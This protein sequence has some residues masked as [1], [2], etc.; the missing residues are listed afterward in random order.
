MR[1]LLPTIF[2]A[3]LLWL[4]SC[5]QQNKVTL[6]GSNCADE[7]PQRTNLTFSFNKDLINDSLMQAGGWQQE[8]FIKFTPNIDGFYRWESN[9]TLVFSPSSAL[10]PA[11]S[12][13]AEI[14]DAVCKFSKFKLG[15]IAVLNFHTAAQRLENF[16]AQWTI[17]NPS[18]KEIGIQADLYFTYPQSTTSLEKFISLSVNKKELPF[19]FSQTENS[20]KCALIVKGIQPTDKEYEIAVEIKKG[21]L[22]I[23]GKN[24]TKEPLKASYTLAS[25]FELTIGNI[26]AAHDG[27]EG[28]ITIF[29]SQKIVNSNMKSLLKISPSINFNVQSTDE[30][31]QITSSEFDASKV[32]EISIAK[33]LKGIIGGEMKDSYFNTVS[34][35]K[36]EP[37]IAFNDK[38]ATY[39]SAKGNKNLLVN[40]VN[41][42]KVKLIIRKVYEN[43]ILPALRYGAGGSYYDDEDYGN[44]GASYAASDIVYEEEINTNRLPKKGESRI[45]NFNF[46]DKLPEFKGIYHASLR[47]TDDYWINDSRIISLSD[48]GLIARQT[49]N[50]IIVF[51]NSI[52]TAKSLGGIE[53]KVF[54]NNNQLIGNAIT[55]N[56]G[57]ATIQLKKVNAPGFYPALV[58]AKSANDFNYISLRDSRIETSRFDV[59]G[60]SLSTTS[61]DAFVYG[62]RDMY[63]PGE[64]INLSAIVRTSEWKTAGEIPVKMK[65]SLPNGMEF[66]SLKKILNEQGSFEVSFDLPPNAITGSYLFELFTANDVLLASKSI[67]VEEFMPDR[68]K[69]ATQLEK[70]LIELNEPIV[71]KG[72][73]QNLFG[74]AAAERNYE[75]ELQLNYFNFA[76]KNFP[77]YN[78][79]L[80]NLDGYFQSTTKQGTTDATGSFKESFALPENIANKGI[81]KAS[82]FTT[83]FDETGRPVNR[84]NTASIFTQNIFLGIQH[85]DYYYQPLNENI[86]FG[87][88]AVNS[89]EQTTSSKAKVQII[90]HEFK[91]V[92]AKSWDY[93]RYESQVDD[94]ILTEQ[95]IDVSGQNTVFNFVPKTPGEYEIR[96]S[97]PEAQSYVQ[98]RFYSYGSWGGSSSN[99]E[100]N[101]EGNIDIEIDKESY[102]NGEQ[103]KLLFKT[104]FNGKMLVTVERDEVMEKFYLNVEN[105]TA[106]ATLQLNARHMPNAY[107]TATLFKAHTVSEMPLTV[108]H[109]FKNIAVAE[110]SRKINVQIEAPEKIRSNTHQKIAVK[111]APNSFITLAVVDEGILQITDYKSP[112]P[113]SFFYS[114]RALEVKGYDFYANLFPEIKTSVISVGGDGFD[115]SKRTNPITNKRV[116]LVRYWSGI[117]QTNSL[118][119]AVFEFDVPQF[120]GELRLMAVNYVNEKFGSAES[121]MK[122]ADP[123]VISAGLPRFLSPGDEADVSL[124]LSNTTR[125]PMNVKIS[126]ETAGALALK[127]IE[128][129]AL[130]I[131]PNSEARTEF[132]VMANNT[133][134]NA[135]VKVKAATNNESF[136][137]ETEIT[138]RPAASLQKIFGSGELQ[139][140]ENKIIT[141]GTNDF[142]KGT[143]SYTLIVS[144]SPLASFGKNLAELIQ[145]P[146]G[147]TE[148]ITAAAFPQIYF[149]ELSDAI[150]ANKQSTKAA[151]YNITEAIK[152]IKLRQLY[153]G[154]IAL[155]DNEGKENWWASVFAAHFLVEAKQNGYEVEDNF[156]N[157]LLLYLES[158]LRNKEMFKY[159]FNRGQSKMLAAREIPYSLYVLS[160]AGKPQQSTMNYYQ[161][162]KQLLAADGKYLLAA[163]YALNGDKSKLNELQAN[164]FSI[165]V[166]DKDVSNSF[167]SDLRD[168]AL[169]LDVLLQVQPDNNQIPVMAKQVAEGLKSR[170]YLSTQELVFSINALGKLAKRDGANNVTAIVKNNGK[171]IGEMKN[172][173][174]KILPQQLKNNQVEI[175]VNGNGK[176]YYFW[177]ASGISASGNIKE[178]DSYLKVRRTFYDRYGRAISNNEFKQNDLVVVGISLENSFGR[179]IENVVIT[180]ML[181]A[182]FEIEN[183]RTKEIPGMNWIKNENYP[184]YTDVRD[185][186]IN[187]FVNAGKTKQTYYYAVRAVSPGI[188]KLG[189]LSADAMYAGE[190]HSYS[191]SGKVVIANK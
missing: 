185:D 41:V 85:S 56:N 91:T 130:S 102:K 53:C 147:C 113:Y 84:F 141:L 109:G 57:N 15:K 16:S 47:S 138:V 142:I 24:E 62:E 30:G 149:S 39:M 89:K 127:S 139:A 154:G 119:N 187:L 129:G 81:L 48:V 171:L 31:M 168:E 161:S 120:N 8:K 80:S 114:K 5:N 33:G 189:I 165:E 153:T 170:K 65:F 177:E 44:Y 90:K 12:F 146:Y 54:G 66:K 13:T 98:Q 180:D 136:V 125:Q 36:L 133:I 61:L 97:L 74:T 26:E 106:T 110:P 148:Q 82:L 73:A 46:K 72:N 160:L 186:R 64:T 105:R 78:F 107:V 182:G 162:N 94:K 143:E 137:D 159:Y 184:I 70:E 155:W 17:I 150:G 34:F 134:G 86:R 151:S 183:P 104:P 179:N 18:T 75:V 157:K 100:V 158:K 164:S 123:I 52:S 23:D 121:F 59:G 115:L 58:T 152:K 103:A 60:K 117:K 92:L 131:A 88:I 99:F 173:S 6:I 175:S 95:T 135:K 144:N 38:S 132:K 55:D 40:I 25:P 21:L 32:Y 145:Y 43:N 191:G 51:A 10:P 108:A 87:I 122:V 116:K 11:T 4:T 118:G 29:T 28:N 77:K 69:V 42:P 140:G 37:S 7:M 50:S 20:Q 76:P 112:D 167:G 128:N 49:Q 35:G 124:T 79:S 101:K 27:L 156:L 174:L 172:N 22:P 169:A 178:E 188:Y 19:S 1:F 14:T 2:A 71:I 96:V 67:L 166:S 3:S 83:V 45:L 163:A 63:R 68:I 93:F 9:N 181:P 190:Y 111:G 176:A 126:I